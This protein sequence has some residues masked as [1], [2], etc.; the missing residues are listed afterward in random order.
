MIAVATVLS[1]GI[2]HDRMLEH[3]IHNFIPFFAEFLAFS[4]NQAH[5]CPIML[6]S[7]ELRSSGDGNDDDNYDGDVGSEVHCQTP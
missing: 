7:I 2:Y 4:Q 6:Q 5:Y 3:S 1:S